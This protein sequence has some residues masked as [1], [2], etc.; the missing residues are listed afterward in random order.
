MIPTYRSIYLTRKI[1]YRKR[2]GQTEL[3][4]RESNNI[5]ALTVRALAMMPDVSAHVFTKIRGFKT[6]IF[7][8]SLP[9]LLVLVFII[10]AF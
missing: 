7:Q 8:Q 6:I 2:L 4:E 1:L 10:A 5:H 9:L 3:Y